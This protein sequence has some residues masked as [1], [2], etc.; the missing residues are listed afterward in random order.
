MNTY[1]R[2]ARCGCKIESRTE[3]DACMDCRYTDPTWVIITER[4][5]AQRREF[6]AS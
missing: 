6:L 1:K 4:K 2:C 5:E 3:Y